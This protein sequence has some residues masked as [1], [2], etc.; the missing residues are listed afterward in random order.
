MSLFS[1]KYSLKW[2]QIWKKQAWLVSLVALICI[3][4]TLVP[5]LEPT[6]F[7][8]HDYT[9]AARVVEM[10]RGLADG[11]VPVRWSA[12]LGYG[13][14][15]PLYI[16]YAPLPY[17][18][19]GMAYLIWPDA[20]LSIKLLYILCAV[21]TFWGC[22]L[23]SL[24]LHGSV[25]A[26]LVS[27]SALSLAPYRAVNF[28]V[29][30]A[31]SEN[32][33]IMSLPWVLLGVMKVVR[34][35][36][37]GGLVLTLSLCTLFL[38]H[39]ITTMIS[40]PFIAAFSLGMLWQERHKKEHSLSLKKSIQAL[41]LSAGLAVGLTAF[42]L[43]PALLEKDL[44]HLK[45][46]LGG[47]FHYSQHFLYIRQ[48][49]T[50]NWGFTGSSWGPDDGMSF[51]LGYGQ[52]LAVVLS[53]GLF[54]ISLIKKQLKLADLATSQFILIFCLMVGS[55]FLSLEKSKP[56]W[57][58]I[59]PLQT[60]QFPWRFLGVGVVFL[61]L[62]CGQL[63]GFIK[64]KTMVPIVSIVLIG[65]FLLNA[66]YFQPESFLDNSEALYFTEPVKIQ[67]KMSGILPDY[68]PLTLD[69]KKGEKQNLMEASDLELSQA[70]LLITCPSCDSS[71]NKVLVNRSQEKL[72]EI[73][74]QSTG[75]FSFHTVFFPGWKAYVDGQEVATRPSD[76][77]TI[78]I[79]VQPGMQ[80]VGLQL[81]KTPVRWWSDLT[82]VLSIVGGLIL[83][84]R[85]G[86]LLK[87]NS[88]LN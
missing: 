81:G 54:L 58:V 39:N 48:F 77:G 8:V 80:K 68:I 64:N 28:Y 18:L 1:S 40:A 71:K 10:A 2:S 30:G 76:L 5:M 37:Y 51:F 46:I 29:R 16:F 19:G 84:Y 86:W 42:Y 20:I 63:L 45:D 24:K 25:W 13:Y 17:Y 79:D 21:L 11:Q 73:S 6:F 49:L 65:A 14:G 23:L 33:G 60:A 69:L 15:M 70:E 50:P 55:L 56:I 26:A 75:S 52:L 3:F 4:S 85:Q 87:K 67:T 44:T 32:W 78:Q 53:L 9:H 74:V 47:Y 36:K 82:T 27:S 66:K 59:Q 38:S 31:V 7:R 35:E 34:G 12:N 43:F 22:Y 72:L 88:N 83:A 41:F 61:S 62:L 57:D